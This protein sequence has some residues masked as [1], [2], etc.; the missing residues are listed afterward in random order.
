MPAGKPNCK[1]AVVGPPPAVDLTPADATAVKKHPI[2]PVHSRG[3]VVPSPRFNFGAARSLPKRSGS[4]NAAL[5]PGATC[6]R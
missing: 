1:A 2:V 3:D 5:H 4:G 6:A